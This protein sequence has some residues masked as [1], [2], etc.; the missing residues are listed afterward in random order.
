MK[1][2]KNWVPALFIMALSLNSCIIDFDGDGD[3]FGTNCIRGSGPNVVEI[4]DINEFDGLSLQISA[5]VFI[6]QGPVFEVRAE[7]Q[8]NII[9]E[10]ELDV[11][12]GFWEIEFDRCVRNSNDLRI[13]ITM[14]VIT[15]LQ[16][17]GSGDIFGE[18]IF[19][20]DDIF[21]RI[22]GSGN[23]DLGLDSDDVN[24]T[25][26]GSGNMRLEGTADDLSIQIA[27]SG[28]VFAFDLAS[29]SAN[30]NIRGSGDAEVAVES[31]LDVRISGSGDVFYKGNPIIDS[32]ISGSGRVIDAN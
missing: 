19:V 28:D 11:R 3:G 17:S 13:Y 8:A 23:M 7:G 12:D 18:N 31:T 22:S 25:I 6:T 5:N 29:S 15:E 2:L 9:R 27:G 21:L 4:L 16:I 1:N 30:I 20:T 24:L 10:L 14:P 32:S 26:S